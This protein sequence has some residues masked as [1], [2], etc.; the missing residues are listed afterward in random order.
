MNDLVNEA[1]GIAPTAGETGDEIEDDV[2][3]LFD[4]GETEDDMEFVESPPATNGVTKQGVRL[5][6]LQ[7]PAPPLGEEAL[8]VP[9]DTLRECA[10]YDQLGSGASCEVFK[11]GFKGRTLALKKLHS[12][13]LRAAHCEIN[14]LAR[15]RHPN[16]V[17]LVATCLS[18]PQPLLLS[19]YCSGGSLLPTHHL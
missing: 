8:D 9:Y 13:E 16:L 10:V 19:E 11:V 17:Q 1:L 5:D 2:F 12:G 18:A 7:Q 14:V 6:A 3:T 4:D 15:L